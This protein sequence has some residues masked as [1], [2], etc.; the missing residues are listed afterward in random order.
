ML[1]GE[2]HNSSASSVEYMK[3]IWDK[4]GGHAPEH[5][6][7]HRQLGTDRTGRRQV[8]LCARRCPDPKRAATA[9]EAG[10]HLVRDVEECRFELRAALGQGGPEALPAH[11]SEGPA[12]HRNFTFLASY[13]EQHGIRSAQSPSVEETLQADAKAFRA[14]MRHIREV[15]P[16]HTVI[17]MQVENEAGSLGDSRDHSSG[18]RG[19]MG[20]AG[21]HR[22]DGLPGRRTKLICSRKQRRS[23]AGTDTRPPAPGLTCSE[24]TNGLTRRSWPTMW[25]ATW[26][27]G[28]GGQSGTEHPDVRERVARP[29]AESG[30]AG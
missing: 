29:A 8:R 15:D 2:L 11:G 21:S 23:G 3:P 27:C 6:H 9:H 26:R 19:C 25:A 14:L 24:M 16:Q 17:M 12:G 28:Q 22:A 7:W 5:G 18:R 4:L 10:P 20:E 30:C 1:A 13:M